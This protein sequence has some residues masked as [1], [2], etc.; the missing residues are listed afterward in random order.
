MG[1][2][3]ASR[4]RPFEDDGKIHLRLL[5]LFKSQQLNMAL[6]AEV[7]KQEEPDSYLI[8]QTSK[9]TF[10]NASCLTAPSE[11]R[12]SAGLRGSC[13][14]VSGS[15]AGRK[16][17]RER[18]EILKSVSRG[19]CRAP[20]QSWGSSVPLVDAAQVCSSPSGSPVHRPV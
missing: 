6:Q 2:Q 20:V 11:P 1:A 3:V 5:R 7:F 15:E 16:V 4:L 13:R 8:S 19:H 14:W 18:T 12:S 17:A 9:Y 10:G